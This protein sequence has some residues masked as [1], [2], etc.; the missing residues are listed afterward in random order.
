M[1]SNHSLSAR[2]NQGLFAIYIVESTR[3]SHTA[4][5]VCNCNC[6]LQNY[7]VFGFWIFF[8]FPSTEALSTSV[9]VRDLKCFF[10]Y[11][12]RFLM[13]MPAWTHGQFLFAVIQT[14]SLF[15]T[16]SVVEATK[17]CL[18]SHVVLV[19]ITASLCVMIH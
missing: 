10:F 7:L 6:I 11:R 5:G 15:L 12:P 3:F 14:T 13:G 19:A 18:V 16:C 9:E 2:R 1:E 8:S 17:F 4:I